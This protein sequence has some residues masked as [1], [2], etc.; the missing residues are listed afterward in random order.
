MIRERIHPLFHKSGFAGIGVVA[1][2]LTMGVALLLDV[3]YILAKERA[4]T[5]LT[6]VEDTFV[7]SGR[8]DTPFGELDNLWIGYRTEVNVQELATILK[9][10]IEQPPL[11]S[12]LSKAELRFYLFQL[13]DARNDTANLVLKRVINNDAWDEMTLTW[14]GYRNN[15][16]FGA[17]YKVS[18]PL[19]I[20]ETRIDVTQMVNEVFQLSGNSL[21]VAIEFPLLGSPGNSYAIFWSKEHSNEVKRPVLVMDFTPIPTPTPGP[22]SLSLSNS[23]TSALSTGGIVTYTIDLR[24]GPHPLSGVVVSNTAPSELVVLSDTVHGGALGWQSTIQGQQITW[25]LNQTLPANAADRL[26]YQAARPTPTPTITPTPFVLPTSLGIVKVG[27]ESVAPGALI[28]YTLRVDNQT[29]YTLTAVTITDTIPHGLE[30]VDAGGGAIT[31]TAGSQ[32]LWQEPAPFGSGETLTKTFSGRVASG[33]AEVVN[34]DYQVQALTPILDA[35]TPITAAGII[36][37]TTRVIEPLPPT[38]EPVII[39]AG[40]CIQWEYTVLRQSYSIGVR[41]SGPVFNPSQYQWL[42]FIAP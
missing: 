5:P 21:G 3:G 13:E 24:N 39:N 33:V 41:C 7:M 35:E 11:N 37:V 17:P 14:Q 25:T 15:L 9:F 4:V 42:P 31:L 12:R 36:S 22:N 19:T 8:K 40:A 2:I 6:P 18:I 32:I 38:P 30:V 1:A 10:D 16:Q 34:H 20:G 28:T 23:P 27:P 29:P 26:S